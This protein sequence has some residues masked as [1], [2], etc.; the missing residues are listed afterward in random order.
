MMIGTKIL[1]R[2]F[3]D[4]E[5]KSKSTNLELKPVKQSIKEF[6]NPK[7]KENE[8]LLSFDIY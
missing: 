1:I 5:S 3:A 4:N 2:L 6:Y 7:L 8:G